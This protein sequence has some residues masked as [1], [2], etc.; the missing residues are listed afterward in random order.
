MSSLPIPLPQGFSPIVVENEEVH[1]GQVIARLI[2]Q[3]DTR[4]STNLQDGIPLATLLNVSI[5]KVPKLLKKE[6]G[7]MI[8]EGEVLASRSKGIHVTDVVSNVTGTIA[9]YDRA[10][11]VLSIQPHK[12]LV[13][14]TLQDTEII[15]PLDGV[16][17]VCNNEQIVLQ[18]KQGVS[19]VDEGIGG[20]THGMLVEVSPKGDTQVI[21]GV[22][23]NVS[24]I[25]GILLVPSLTKEAMVKA[26]SMGIKGAVVK[27]LTAEDREYLLE[28]QILFPV[29][30]VDEETY[31]GLKKQVGEEVFMDPTAKTVSLKI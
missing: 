4:N 16:V 15:S 7:D 6:P 17:R 2:K 8:R 31:K 18:T 11:G 14:D 3:D 25:E 19:S 20:Q 1:Q 23:L 22:D 24:M 29:L 28:K 10:S 30:A 12:K 26:A 9:G 5:K 13:K 27:V 21:D